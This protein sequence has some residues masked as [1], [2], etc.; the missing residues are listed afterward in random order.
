M[1]GGPPAPPILYS[2]PTGD[3]LIESLAHFIV[4]AQKEAVDKKG[5]FT[6][7][8]SGGSLPKQLKG[9]VGHAGVKWDKWLINGHLVFL[10]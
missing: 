10:L 1:P 8:L 6:I 4:K 9:L 3:Q 5:R 7:A 2:F